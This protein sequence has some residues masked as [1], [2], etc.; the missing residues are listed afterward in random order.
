MIDWE[1]AQK[2]ELKWGRIVG[3]SNY[4]EDNDFYK[5]LFKI[6]GKTFRGKKVV[7]IGAGPYG[8]VRSIV[9]EEK[10]IIEPLG[11]EYEKLYSRDVNIQYIDQKAESIDLKSETIDFVLLLN[12]I[13]HC[14]RPDKVIKEVKR[15]LIKGGIL[16]FFTPLHKEI[17][18]KHL[19]SYDFEKIIYLL[20]DFKFSVATVTKKIFGGI[21][22]SPQCTTKVGSRITATLPPS[23]CKAW[24]NL[25]SSAWPGI[26]SS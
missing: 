17:D 22:V 1:N 4:Q 21:L 13:N 7:E 15:I 2:H 12:V 19:Y 23:F 6:T 14:E 25:T 3:T 9:A 20:R 26:K 10:I 8:L 18:N 5:D 16:Y 24:Q 11:K